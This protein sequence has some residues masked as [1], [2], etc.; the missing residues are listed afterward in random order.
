MTNHLQMRH[1]QKPNRDLGIKNHN[2]H[3]QSKSNKKYRQNQYKI[4]EFIHNPRYNPIQLIIMDTAD[5]IIIE[6]MVKRVMFQIKIWQAILY[7][8]SPIA[9]AYPKI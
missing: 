8:P 2:P 1:Q 4:K 3:T 7:N 9:I 6:L 5:I